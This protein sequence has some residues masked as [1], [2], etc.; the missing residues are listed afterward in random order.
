MYPIMWYC[1]HHIDLVQGL[2]VA[3][4]HHFRGRSRKLCPDT[5]VIRPL[6]HEHV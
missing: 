3:R 2:I 5:L 1:I 6:I 4:P